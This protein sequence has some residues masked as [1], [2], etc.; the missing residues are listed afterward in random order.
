MIVIDASA[1]TKYVLHEENWKDVA[2]FIRERKPLYSI[3]H[4]LKE[5]GNAIWKHSYLRKMIP[6]N[7]ALTLYTRVLRLAETRVLQLEPEEKYLTA[8]LEIALI[9]GTTFYDSLYI[10]Q[11]LKHGELLTSDEKQAKIASILDIKTYFI[12]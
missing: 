7:T 10:A 3:D 12:K 11:A 9:Q 2:S 8:A 5:V 6:K 4:V 1:L